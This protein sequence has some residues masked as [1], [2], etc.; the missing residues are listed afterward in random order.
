MLVVHADKATRDALASSLGAAGHRAL[1]SVA[2]RAAGLARGA[3]DAGRR[4]V[5]ALVAIDDENELPDVDLVQSVDGPVL[6][7][8]RETDRAIGA[9]R[10]DPLDVAGLEHIFIEHARDRARVLVAVSCETERRALVRLVARAGH[11]VAISESPTELARAMADVADVV[12]VDERFAAATAV[13]E[14]VA[15]HVIALG[16]AAPPCTVATLARPVSAASLATSLAAARRASTLPAHASRDAGAVRPVIDRADLLARLDQDTEMAAE[17]LALFAGRV[18]ALEDAVER[19]HA[20]DDRRALRRAAH[21][22]LGALLNV[23]AYPA[24]DAARRIEAA[25]DADER[26]DVAPLVLALRAALTSVR[27]ALAR[28]R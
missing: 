26:E 19:A 15:A 5:A 18:D 8:A 27:A 2:D 20:G 3:R 14:A 1:V 9:V 24:A 22:L 23:S 12:I 28:A 11:A 17:L 7:L 13:F 25:I 16:D 10:A 4:V 21:S 6:R